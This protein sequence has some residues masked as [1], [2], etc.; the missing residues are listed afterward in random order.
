M[1]VG[2]HEIR[3]IGAEF[4]VY[5]DGDQ[6]RVTLT[7]GVVSIY[8][9]SSLD[10]ASQFLRNMRLESM[11]KNA[12][13]VLSMGQQA[14]IIPAGP[15]M[16]ANVDPR[17]PLAWQEGRIIFEDTPLG[18]AVR[19]V[20]RYRLRQIVLATPGLASLTISGVFNTDRLDGFVEAL[21]A[22]LPVQVQR[23]DGKTTVLKSL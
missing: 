23:D 7:N 17:V 12:S 13:V 3:A 18:Q 1:F 4:D 16:V 9:A 22:A 2:D 6:T 19:D 8:E 14:T 21:I 15:I 20:N 10:F 5:R 11:P